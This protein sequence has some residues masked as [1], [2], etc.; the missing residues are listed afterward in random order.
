MGLSQQ[1]RQ[2]QQQRITPAMLMEFSLLQLPVSELREA[3]KKEV[4]S[5]PA[6][7]VD[8][9]ASLLTPLPGS[10]GSRGP[11]GDGDK[12]GLLE[13]VGDERGE[14]LDEHILSELRMSG[15]E[16]RELA[17]CGAIVENLDGD[18]RYTGVTADLIMVLEGSGVKGVTE[19]E[20][21]SARQRVMQADPPGCGARSLEECYRAQVP[22]VPA[23]KRPLVEAAIAYVSAVL[24]AQGTRRNIGSLTPPSAEALGLL[25]K[26]EAYPGRLYDRRKTEYVLPD[27]KVDASGGVEVDQ[28]DIPDLRVSPKYVE[29]AKDREL[30]E[31]TRNFAAE[32][33]KRAREFR[34]AVIRRK[35]TMERI[36][37]LMVER[38]RPFLEEGPA[39][40]RRLTMSE[41]AKEAKCTIATVSR[42]AARK[43]V[44]TPRG[45]VPMRKF[46]VLVDQAP[47]EK[48]REI[49]AGLPAGVETSDQKVAAL[50]EKA[51][52]KMARRTINK[53]RRKLGFS[54]KRPPNLV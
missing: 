31:E 34:E 30:D 37:E 17:L 3:V 5:N 32:R 47:I 23:A 25:K 52:Y 4:D 22:S 6:L 24:A 28:G 27:V 1:I 12:E 26:L 38:H 46:F 21:E 49:L 11:S 9:D 42:A 20:L 39:G 19:A 13:N 41:I 40:L 7:E 48:L 36:A 2:T 35:E 50:L 45:T 14:T 43:Y 18:G 53:Y 16:G 44:R 10:P 8:R 15:V 29:M 54:T 51:G 33:V